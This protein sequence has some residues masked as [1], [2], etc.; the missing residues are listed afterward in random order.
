MDYLADIF[1]S[2]WPLVGLLVGFGFLIFIHE[3]GHHVVAKLVG[4]KVTQFAVGFGHSVVAWR[5]G[6]GLR[7]GSTE[8]E[9]QKRLDDGADPESM[10]ETEYRLNWM[11]LGGYVKML[12]Q[13]DLNPDADSEDERS[14]TR[15]PVW[16]RACVIS[17]GVIMNLIF[18][19]VFFVIAFMSGVEFPPA[20]VGGVQ[21]G[22]PAATSYA[23]GHEGD[24]TYLG[25]RAGDRV[26][27][28]DGVKTTDFADVA[29]NAALAKGGQTIEMTIDRDGASGPLLYNIAPK[30]DPK[31]GLLTLGIGRPV[32]LTVRT[33]GKGRSLPALIADA[34]VKPDMVAT[35]V[36]KRPIQRYDQLEQAI[37]AAAG[38]PVEVR[39]SD[40][41]GSKPSV[42][43]TVAAK[44]ILTS[45]TNAPP[46]LLGLVPATQIQGV[47]P[48]SPAQAGGV[49]AGDVL[50]KIGDT[51]W[52]TVDQVKDVVAASPNRAIPITVLRDG[53]K[54][55]LAP[56]TP[57]RNKRLGV[58]LAEA[59][60]IPVVSQTTADSPMGTLNLNHGS[61]ILS[62]NG[63]AVSSYSEM[64]RLLAGLVDAT[65]ESDKGTESA[66]QP[67]EISVGYQLNL[68]ETAPAVGS[69]AV[70]P[71]LIAG[72]G[73]A[74]PLASA[75]GGL[76]VFEMLLVPV[77]TSS[78]LDATMM[79]LHKTRQFMLQTYVTLGRLVQG[80][81]KPKH[82]RG[83]V[84]ITDEGT[85]FAKQGYPYLMFFLG[86]I[87][88]NLAVINFLPLPIVD[89]GL[90]VL[91]MIEK[92]KGSPVRAEIQAAIT[93]V[94]LAVIGGIFLIT[95]FYDVVRL[96]FGEA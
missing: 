61:R 29:V 71:N 89:G 58:M 5:K 16:A 9:Y 39:F 19:V 30:K 3:L 51:P 8:Q 60:S 81:V 45:E 20:L 38:E 24:E 64:Q 50:A 40:A 95:L 15:K 54:I 1:N 47:S 75:A 68:A 11:P 77:T 74:D 41:A 18:G 79:G 83:P 2:T 22:S 33:P 80:T 94:G 14:F 72:I 93:Y 86:L 73:W 82:L 67:I 57:G 17:A 62:I 12:G 44:P 36:G 87:S 26:T 96:V 76:P 42:R 28:I 27:M 35:H 37:I 90:M 6:I 66:Q 10:G 7:K 34:G 46:N 31:S 91:L 78:P 32:S 48:K 85:R 92:L 23:S 59:T 70:D 53:Q 69:I 43:I 55:D 56:I 21:P 25:L 13:E 84:G 65:P 88:V 63:Q 52:P 49:E 4:I